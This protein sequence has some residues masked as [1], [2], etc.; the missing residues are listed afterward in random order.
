MSSVPTAPLASPADP[1]QVTAPPVA[2]PKTGLQETLHFALRNRKLVFGLSMT[3]A[4]LLFAII[5][6]FIAQHGPLD[7]G[8]QLSLAPTTKDGY[9]FGTTLLR[10][11][12]SSRSS[13]PDCALRS[14][15]AR[16]AA[17]SRRSSAWSIGFTAGYRGGL[18]DEVPEHAHERRPRHPDVRAPARDRRLPAGAR[19]HDG[20]RLHR[21]HLVALGGARAPRAD[22]LA[23]LARLR[24]H[25]AP[26]RRAAAGRSSS[27]RSRRT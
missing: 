1:S 15:S 20:G 17:G 21:A 19:D 24:R 25:G 22:V 16:S 6:P 13:P 9:W 11:R 14:S 12:T 3:A 27:R 7:Y 2:R 5:G 10:A 8:G 4:L 18:V 23:R 26:E